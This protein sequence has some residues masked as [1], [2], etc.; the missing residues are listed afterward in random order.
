MIQ[1]GTGHRGRPLS[2]RLCRSSVSGSGAAAPPSS[3]SSCSSPTRHHIT[4]PPVSS[5]RVGGGVST[6]RQGQRG[7]GFSRVFGRGGRKQRK[8][9]AHH[10]RRGARQQLRI[11]RVGSDEA[12]RGAAGGGRQKVSC[13]RLRC[14]ANARLGCA[15]SR[16]REGGGVAARKLASARRVCFDFKEK[17]NVLFGFCSCA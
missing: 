5:G 16:G 9:A 12:R 10:S 7:R 1:K 11:R 4:S 6:G 2:A 15:W 13:T 3:G 8:H 14:P 17:I